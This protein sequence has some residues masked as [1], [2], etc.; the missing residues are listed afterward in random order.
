MKWAESLYFFLSLQVL[1]KQMKKGKEN[2]FKEAPWAF[3]RE[4]LGHV[5]WKHCVYIFQEGENMFS[6][7]LN[8]VTLQD[9]VHLCP[10]NEAVILHFTCV[11]MLC[12]GI[13]IPFPSLYSGET[14]HSHPLCA[15]IFQCVG[16]LFFFNRNLCSLPNKTWIESEELS[17][18]FFV[19]WQGLILKS[20]R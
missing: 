12:R 10:D 20:E 9:V 6:V 17:I 14:C 11:G 4:R 18:S 15:H 2:C 5:D 1:T 3:C 7:L 8:Y 19:F 16:E 13:S